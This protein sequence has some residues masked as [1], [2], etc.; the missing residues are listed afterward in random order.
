MSWAPLGHDREQVNAHE[1]D[2][3]ALPRGSGHGLGDRLAQALVSIG[4]HQANSLQASLDQTPK[5]AH[6]E[7]VVLASARG[8]PQDTPLARLRDPDRDD[9]GDRGDPAGLTDLVE[10][11][12]EPEV[13]V[14]VLDRATQEGSYLLVEHLADP[15]DLG[16][17][18]PVDAERADQVVD[19]ARELHLES[20]P[21]LGTLTPCC[22]T[23]RC[24]RNIHRLPHQ[25]CPRNLPPGEGPPEGVVG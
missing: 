21:L 19:L 12:V 7:L 2:T 4:D 23:S 6:P 3:A 22:L 16:A 15:G 5:E 20:P 1:V 8:D 24:P 11:G 18:D 10:R 25:R 14:L 13:G 17:G 9:R